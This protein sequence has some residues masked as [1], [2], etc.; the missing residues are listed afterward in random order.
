MSWLHVPYH[1]M[2]FNECFDIFQF[3]ESIIN[4]VKVFYNTLTLASSRW[5]ELHI[6]L[7]LEE[8][9]DKGTHCLHTF[10]V[11]CVEILALKIR[12]NSA[13]IGIK[14]TRVEHKFSQFADDTSLV[15][16]GGEKY[17]QESLLK[18]D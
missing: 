4:W 12:G 17:L 18:L 11:L 8:I 2:F 16:K 5:L 3:G 15:L 9:L 6:F 7:R 1:G 13:I 10:I 14:V